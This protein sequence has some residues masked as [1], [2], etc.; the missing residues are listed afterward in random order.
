MSV[1]EARGSNCEHNGRERIRTCEYVD[2]YERVRF[3]LRKHLK[4][5]ILDQGEFVF[6]CMAD[7]YKRRLLS[8]PNAAPHL[9]VQFSEATLPCLGGWLDDT[10]HHSLC[11]KL[12]TGILL[13]VISQVTSLVVRPVVPDLWRNVKIWIVEAFRD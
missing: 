1:T 11:C 13:P 8:R 7:E 6:E 4:D 10:L 3:V 2:P 12:L 9:I 5:N